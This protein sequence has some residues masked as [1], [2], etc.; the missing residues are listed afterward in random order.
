M[1]DLASLYIKV[2]SKGVVTAGKDLDKL[3]GTS[4]GAEKA[5][6]SV[7]KSFSNQLM[8]V[9][10]LAKGY[11]AL[12]MAQYI[13]DATMLAARYE[14]LGVVMRVVGNN[15]GYT[16]A[17]MD[18]FTRSL[19]ETGI[20]LVESRQSIT[21]M[22]QA[23]LDLTKASKLA[24]VAQDA[25]V[26]GNINS[27]EAF[28]RLVYGIQSAQAEVLRNIGINV[29]FE[30]SYKKVADA[31]DRA[32]TS[33]SEAEKAEIRMDAVLDSNTTIASS[34]AASMETVGK[35]MLSL[36]RYLENIKVG[37]GLA[38]T[39]ALAEIIESITGSLKTLNG[40]LTEGSK[41]KIND[42]GVNFR[43]AIISI[44]AEFMRLAMLI[45]KIGGTMTSAQMLLYGP[46]A[47]LGIESSTK[48]FEAAADANME[49][50]R[51]YEETD[52]ALEALALKQIRLEQ[53]LTKEGKATAKARADALEATRLASREQTEETGKE[54]KILKEWTELQKGIGL[55]SV[56]NE[57][58][59][60]DIKYENFKKVAED[61]VALEKWKQDQ[62]LEIQANAAN[63]S[64]ALYQELYEA[65]GL[66]EYAE[67]AISEYAKVLDAA[68]STWGGILEDEED[69][70]TLRLKKEEE[71]A[72][73]LYGIFDDIV[74][75]EQDAADDRLNV[76]RD[77]TD[78]RISEEGRGGAATKESMGIRGEIVPFESDTSFQMTWDSYVGWLTPGVI[79]ELD[80]NQAIIENAPKIAAAA[81]AREAAAQKAATDAQRASAD[82][83]RAAEREAQR[84]RGIADQRVRL[85]IQTLEATGYA[86][87][88][89]GVQRLFELSALDESLR[90][91]QQRLYYLEDEAKAAEEAAEASEKLIEA[92]KA[93]LDV[94]EDS[95]SALVSQ[96]KAIKDFIN[97]LGAAGGA[98]SLSAAR[99]SYAADLAGAKTGDPEAYS[100]VTQSA[101]TYIS[102]AGQTARSSVEMARIVAGIKSELSALQPVVDLESNIELLKAIKEATK[103]TATSTDRLDVLGIKAIFD[104]EQTLTLVD[105]SEGLPD[106]LKKMIVAQSGDYTLWLKAQLDSSVSDDL[107]R[108][109]IDGAGIYAASVTATIG[110]VDAK[111][112]KLV[113][114]TAK[115]TFQ[116]DI[117]A[118]FESMDA[119]SQ[120]L[121]FDAARK[122]ET[123]VSSVYGNSDAKSQ[124]LVFDAGRDY[125]TAVSAAFE[126][127]DA[128]SQK[129][130]FDAA[131]KYTANVFASFV[132]ADEESQ[133]LAIDARGHYAATVDS[134]MGSCLDDESK[135]LAITAEGGYLSTV[136]A[137]IGNVDDHVKK[138]IFPLTE[139]IK[140]TIDASLKPGV[141]ESDA[142]KLAL[143]ETN[144]MTTRVA[145][146]MGTLSDGTVSTKDALKA[147]ETYSDLQT[148]VAAVMGALSDGTVTDDTA[149]KILQ[150]TIDRTAKI[151]AELDNPAWASNPAANPAYQLA[152]AEG[153]AYSASVTAALKDGDI[154]ADELS[155]LLSGTGLAVTEIDGIMTWSPEKSLKTI[156]EAIQSSTQGT[157]A[158]TKKL[159]LASV[160][161][162]ATTVE[163]VSEV[164]NYIDDWGVPHYKTVNY[165]TTTSHGINYFT[166]GTK[167]T[168]AD[169]GVFT[170]GIVTKPTLFNNSQ[171][172]EA[173]PEAIMPLTQGPSGLGVRAIGADSPELLAEIKKL[174]EEAKAGDLALAKN[175]TK[176]AKI[177]S[178][179]DDDGIPAERAANGG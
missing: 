56:E 70:A 81:A 120:A 83:Q 19:Q 68:E 53:S 39:P 165:A 154:T 41:E 28:Q 71:F 96:G 112:Q 51:R 60:L 128:K 5:T 174:R 42:W 16:G 139:I 150:G 17:Q 168:Y 142:G 116:T 100:R 29:N 37:F 115:H 91:L 26:I 58:R 78:N 65:T 159:L 151:A 175:S 36:P 101:G 114:D 152:L 46:G 43:I 84:L 61:E 7:T 90:P 74:D 64:V 32:T 8:V 89:L 87:E 3:T 52:K 141:L 107:K 140:R 126:T 117:N 30:T 50:R 148:N 110:T 108:V 119:K 79:K 93:S 6:E 167:S 146:V 169:G 62:I 49:Y 35:Q 145:A 132:S 172:G 158:N 73:K 153:S 40:E 22:V 21:R 67:K 97:S 33:F 10:T 118:V 31:T 106:H 178:R 69:I 27:S 94:F 137:V 34:Y 127:A 48:R 122:Y 129:L 24:R 92:Q 164:L 109:L 85:E 14:T 75:A 160:P 104:L 66:D 111:S 82:A 156:W 170:N 2:D 72:D 176:I 144:D 95:I 55:T 155:A 171:M 105:N 136:T 162:T 133:K 163:S 98:I 177:L 166:D 11:A 59:L 25:A 149:T 102:T 38:F 147:L 18:E 173:G 80:R 57:L 77:F 47:A 45:D 135:K 13:K 86:E 88:A 9:K 161:T 138:I 143:G 123:D 113:F 4:H 157:A 134:I 23:H 54:E 179:F 44:E 121:V 20:S 12:K 124:T 125:E 1:P 63:Q 130:V 103:D 76:I 131:R 99:A 15:A